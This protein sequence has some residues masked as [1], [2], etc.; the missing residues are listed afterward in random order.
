VTLDRMATMATT[1]SGH[2]FKQVRTPRS[3]LAEFGV[4]WRKW[5]ESQRGPPRSVTDRARWE[6]PP[7][8]S[9]SVQ[10]SQDH[11]ATR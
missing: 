10:H 3:D 9:N 4:Y 5:P 6:L 2:L 11:G 7:I 8:L 1:S